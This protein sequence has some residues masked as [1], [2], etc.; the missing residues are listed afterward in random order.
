MA[1]DTAIVTVECE[2]ET[3]RKLSNGTVLNDLEWIRPQLSENWKMLQDIEIY[4]GRLIG[5]RMVYWT[6]LF[7]MTLNH[8]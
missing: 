3:V 2:Q 4:N 5:S 1:Q 7:S 6:A 8:P